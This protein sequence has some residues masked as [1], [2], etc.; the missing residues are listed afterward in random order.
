MDKVFL[1][2]PVYREVPVQFIL[3]VRSMID[4]KLITAFGSQIGD[5]LVSR[6]RNNLT[7]EFLKTDCDY[8]LQIDSDIVFNEEHIVRIKSHD[9][10]IVGGIYPVKEKE[11]RWCLN[12]FKYNIQNNSELLS[13]AETGTGFLL[14]HRDVFEAI[15][16]DDPA[17]EYVC[18]HD[19]EIK[20][21]YWRV[22]VKNRRYL[23]ED[24]W[25]CQDAR[26]A[27]FDILVDTKIILGH[28]GN[29]VYPLEETEFKI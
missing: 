23:S 1:G 14:V 22:G 10:P 18:D 19:G 12:K 11:T 17:R 9:V 2:T 3:N 21:D 8:L 24:W 16:D 15:R 4:R 26:E 29:V 5:S 27:G 28:I 25:F 20:Y 6:A 7:Y 13:V